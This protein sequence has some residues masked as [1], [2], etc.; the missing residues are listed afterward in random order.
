MPNECPYDSISNC[1]WVRKVGCYLGKV[2]NYLYVEPELFCQ[3]KWI[4]L[5][6]RR[7]SDWM[8]RVLH[9]TLT[10]VNRKSLTDIL[11]YIKWQYYI[12]IL[13]LQITIKIKIKMTVYMY[14]NIILNDI[15]TIN[16]AYVD[17]QIHRRHTVH[18]L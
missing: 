15:P 8:G 5:K 9:F 2:G 17:I 3:K 11:Y 13:S 14:F 12:V 10:C 6:T 4:P 18:C 16:I 7:L 1:T